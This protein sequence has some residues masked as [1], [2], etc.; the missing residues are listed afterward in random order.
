MFNEPTKS[1][2][3][4]QA[5]WALVKRAMTTPEHAVALDQYRDGCEALMPF[6]PAAGEGGSVRAEAPVVTPASPQPAV[7]KQIPM[8][9]VAALNLKSCA[10]TGQHKFNIHTQ[11]CVFCDKTRR[12]ALARDPELMI[13]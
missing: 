9:I 8:E 1:D 3:Q 2:L 12:Q 7:A 6:A 5:G 4:A 10:E 13:Q 11:R